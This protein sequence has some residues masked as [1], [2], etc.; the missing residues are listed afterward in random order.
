MAKERNRIFPRLARLRVQSVLI[1]SVIW[2]IGCSGSQ[3]LSRYDL[4]IA[5]DQIESAIESYREMLVEDWENIEIRYRLANALFL[6][7]KLDEAQDEIEK[8]ILLEKQND[9]YRLL[10]G[11]IAYGRKNFFDATN[12]LI[13]TLLLNNRSI[14]A[15]YYLALTY[16]E[17]EK[18]TDS[19]KQLETA[20]GIEPMNFEAQLLWC[21]ISYNTLIS[22]SSTSNK[23]KKATEES[24]TRESFV[25][26]AERL[27]KALLFKP[28][29]AEGNI[30]LAKIYQAISEV[31]YAKALLLDF[32]SK[33]PVNDNI[34]Y[35]IALINY[36]MGDFQ[37]TLEYLNRIVNPS[38][39]SRILKLRTLIKI[40]PLGDYQTQVK[41]LREEM[42]E[43]PEIWLIQGE[44]EYLK[45]ELTQ[46]ERSLQNSINL[47]P[48]FSTSYYVL[49][50]VFKA[51][52]DSFGTEWALSKAFELAPF[53][54]EIRIDYIREHIATGDYQ[55]AGSALQH[56][57]LNAMDSDV[58][59]LKG[60]LAKN[61]KDYGTAEKS[62]NY[63]RQFDYSVEVEAELAGIEIAKDR[64]KL[65]ENRL[66]HVES[67]Y[68]GTLPVA[69]QRA[70]IFEKMGKTDQIPSLLKPHL[71]N[72]KGK[73]KVHLLTGEAHGRLGDLSAA[74]NV[75]KKGLE[76]WPRQLDLVQAYSFYLGLAGRYDIAIEVLEDIQSFDHTLK[77]MFYHRLK[78]FYYQSGKMEKYKQY[79]DPSQS[80][81]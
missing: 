57:S 45:G 39:K 1:F 62:F 42:P 54:T 9:E 10:A 28:N 24:S 74:I 61:K 73:G 47:N 6:I 15:Y 40:D 32:E 70:A 17:T 34:T 66:N 2:L 65:A 51:Q 52:R 25:E 11:K 72:P 13:N 43:S 31:Q 71:S 80:I 36:S 49:S 33:N 5:D 50:K 64:I 14:E 55:A 35:E 18:T 29:S 8:V 78:T 53:D 27:K 30:L 59:F 12:H 58:V 81:H 23:N 26:L 44:L 67:I 4:M 37:D 19:L 38:G 16:R 69:L 75:L 60:L 63:V 46:A 77:L 3:D 76:K 21:E 41:E 79:N 20:I 7:E 48:G 22:S 68:P 56:S